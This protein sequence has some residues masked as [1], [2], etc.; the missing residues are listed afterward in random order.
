MSGPAFVSDASPREGGSSYSTRLSSTSIGGISPKRLSSAAYM[1][2]GFNKNS[3]QVHPECR[4][5]VNGGCIQE[6]HSRGSV[7]C[8]DQSDRF[9]EIIG[10][11]TYFIAVERVPICHGLLTDK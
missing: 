7:C 6:D 9:M 10:F 1:Y 4:D 11:E 5:P 8:G 2:T 3:H